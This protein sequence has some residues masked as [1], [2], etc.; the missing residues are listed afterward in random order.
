MPITTASPYTFS[1]IWFLHNPRRWV[2]S[3]IPFARGG[4]WGTHWSLVQTCPFWRRSPASLCGATQPCKAQ[5][6]AVSLGF[7]L[8]KAP[9]QTAPDFPWFD[10]GLFS[11]EMVQKWCTFRLLW[12][13]DLALF[14]GWWYA[15]LSAICCRAGPAS[16]GPGSPAVTRGNGWWQ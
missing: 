15:V 3:L 5:V 8:G 11:F 9:N 1:L 7:L 12:I 10:L 2:L 14:P 16:H 6:D 13:W 4:D